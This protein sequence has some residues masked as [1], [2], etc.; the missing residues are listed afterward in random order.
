MVNSNRDTMHQG[1]AM[2]TDT[3]VNNCFS[4]ISS[5]KLK[6]HDKNTCQNIEKKAI[7]K[8]LFTAQPQPV[9]NASYLLV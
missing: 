9:N 8:A 6:Y 3:E 2:F 7:F 4:I 1:N 5:V